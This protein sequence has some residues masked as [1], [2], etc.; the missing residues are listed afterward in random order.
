M[1]NLH[2]LSEIYDFDEKIISKGKYGIESEVEANEALPT[3][4]TEKWTSKLDQSL[5]LNGMEYISNGPLSD[6][7]LETQVEYLFK[8]LSKFKVIHDSPRTSTHVHHNMTSRTPLKIMTCCVAY[9][10]VENILF[11]M[12][13]EDREGN[14]FCLR[15]KD[16]A[17]VVNYLEEDIKAVCRSASTKNHPFRPFGYIR[18]ADHIRYGGLNIISLPK[19]GTI[20]LRGMRGV[21][22]SEVVVPWVRMVDHLF[23]CVD[24]VFSNPMDVILYYI[25]NGSNTFINQLFGPYVKYIEKYSPPNTWSTLID[26]N[27][28]Y[29]IPMTIK[30]DWS[31]YDGGCQAYYEYIKNDTGK[32]NNKTRFIVNDDIDLGQLREFAIRDV[33]QPQQPE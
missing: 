2:K 19:F 12:C 16:A 9:W 10:M 5:R 14:L 8:R 23:T 29:L 28:K 22:D 20:E 27:M 18:N 13:G 33:P 1:G 24:N 7:E 11:R 15:L 25:K 30:T 32:K 31:E 26:G 6:S 17:G 21:Y 3:I 4:K